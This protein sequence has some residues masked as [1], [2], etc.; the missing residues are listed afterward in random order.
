MNLQTAKG[1]RDIAPEEKLGRN[2]V[3]DTLRNTFE[4][5]GFMPLETPVIE[6]YDMLSSKYAGG[7]EI[8]KETFKFKDQGKR[9][10][11]MRYDLTVPMCRFVGM[12]PNL[13]MP[14]KRY[15]IGP[16][17][18]DGPIKLG[19]YRQFVQCDVDIVGCKN[20]LAEAELLSISKMAFQKMGLDVVIKVNSRKL[21]NGILLASG[22]LK[23]KW[24][25]AILSIDKLEKFGEKAVREELGKKGIKAKE[26][27]KLMEL[28]LTQ[29]RL[30]EY[31]DVIKNAE[32]KEGILELQE[33]FEYLESMSSPVQFDPTLARG[34]SYYTGTVF[35]IFLK[36]GEIKSALAG[37]G[38][39]DNMIGNFLG[40]NKEF[41]A[42]G[43][44]FGLDVVQDA[45]GAG[46]VQTTTKVFIIPIGTVKESAA[47]A[48]E[49][50]KA[51]VNCEMD[52]LRRGISKNM[53]YAN[54]KKI[55][56]V[57]FLGEDE[58]KK[59]KVKIKDMNSG[60]EMLLSVK[61]AIEKIK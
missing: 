11:G 44:S 6:R 15:E 26:R 34:L 58:V 8:L 39:Y 28:L 21:L 17:F 1:V 59:D 60:D 47:V 42:V 25:D 43:I 10:L 29:R 3:V 20:M 35:E 37:G 30:P 46:T 54:S 31:N 16:V 57:I 22:V 23:S 48:T 14:F 41:P 24:V 45:M 18:R 12:N 7:D 4:L 19:R 5:F 49:L 32:G 27:D 53:N 50:R 33:L 38:R 51:G 61:E 9:E 52:I 36:K 13:K 55:P 2:K 56:Y 40:G